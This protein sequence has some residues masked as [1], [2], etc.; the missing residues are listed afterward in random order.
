MICPKCQCLLRITKS[1]H[2]AENDATPDKPTKVY[3]VQELSCMNNS[4]NQADGDVIVSKPCPNNGM[5]L[6]TVRH[7]IELI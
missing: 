5:V 2:V 4:F 6:E 3:H 1:Y 7:E